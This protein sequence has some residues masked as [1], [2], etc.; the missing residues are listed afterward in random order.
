MITAVAMYCIII[1]ESGYR[2]EECQP[3][4]EVMH[5]S[6][7]KEDCDNWLRQENRRWKNEGW[8]VQMSFCVNT[9]I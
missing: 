7:T 9:T 2:R 1:V 5:Q 6:W 3:I 8:R 4:H